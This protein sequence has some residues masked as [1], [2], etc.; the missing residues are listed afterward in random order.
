[1]YRIAGHKTDQKCCYVH[2]LPSAIVGIELKLVT[3]YLKRRQVAHI[4]VLP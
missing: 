2:T 3:K 4:I 1:L